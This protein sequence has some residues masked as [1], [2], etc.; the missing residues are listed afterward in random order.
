MR[1]GR[2]PGAHRRLVRCENLLDVC[3]C[4]RD[5]TQVIELLPL[6]RDDW[7]AWR[8]DGPGALVADGTRRE[9]VTT[10]RVLR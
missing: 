8:A 3:A 1:G 6:R 10:R 2:P 7:P 9:L 4:L 5:T